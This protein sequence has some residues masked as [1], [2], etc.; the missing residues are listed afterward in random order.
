MARGLV[1]PTARFGIG[2]QGFRIC[3]LR[4]E[5]GPE[6]PLGA[7]VRGMFANIG[8]GAGTLGRRPQAVAAGQARLDDRHFLP[9]PNRLHRRVWLR[10]ALIEAA[11]AAS[12]SK[13]TYL[14]A[15]YHR[16]AARR[17][18]KKV[19]VALAH[20]LLTIIYYLLTRDRDYEDLGPEYLNQHDREQTERRLIRRLEGFGYTVTREHA[21]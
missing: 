5:D 9:V 7:E 11:H 10:A 21:A 16:V 13:D 17:G 8:V 1:T 3:T 14:A 6:G 15:Y 18:K 4:S 20:T 2:G 12:R 19:N